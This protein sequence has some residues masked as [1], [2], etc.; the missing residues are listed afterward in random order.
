MRRNHEAPRKQA[1]SKTF[2][3]QLPEG[4][5][6]T[7]AKVEVAGTFTNWEK[8]PMDRQVCG[9]WQVAL[10]QISGNRT[11]HYMLL[12]D[13]KPIQDRHCDGLAIPQS[14]EEE[15]FAIATVRGPRVFMLFAQTK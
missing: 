12:A 4:H 8:V 3:W 10:H 5:A 11:H 6:G 9:S 15:Q 2:R 14:P 13:D 7:P 1:F